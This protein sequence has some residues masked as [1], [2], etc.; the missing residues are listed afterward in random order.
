[1]NDPTE[2]R[3]EHLKWREDMEQQIK[4]NTAVTLETRDKVDE[5]HDLLQTMKGAIKALG[6]IGTVAK[7]VG[8]VAGA[9]SAVLV[10]WYQVTH[11]GEMPK[12]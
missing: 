2:R 8:I 12:K 3:E 6:W 9:T 1:L 4:E 7:W 11:G 10:V 5:V